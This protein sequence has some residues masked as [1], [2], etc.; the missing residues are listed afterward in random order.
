MMKLVIWKE[1]LKWIY[2]MLRVMTLQQN[3]IREDELEG[4]TRLMVERKVGRYC[5]CK[6]YR[7]LKKF[8]HDPA[9]SKK[10]SS[11]LPID[12]NIS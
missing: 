6:N 11:I 12:L 3:I 10:F 8:I 9:I 5:F 4:P 1:S 2:L 7:V